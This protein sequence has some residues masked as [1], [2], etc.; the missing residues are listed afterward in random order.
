MTSRTRA[1]HTVCPYCNE[2]V[3]LEELI[4]GKC[5]LC[6]SALED[7]EDDCLE[8]D[9]GLERSDLSWLICHYF[10][11]KKLDDLGANPLQA[12]QIIEKFEE[13]RESG[14]DGESVTFE[15]ELPYTRREQLLPKR[16]ADCG[17]LF[18][19]GGKKIFTGDTEKPGY[20]VFFRC[21]VCSQ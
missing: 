14:N 16:C 1:H 12:M 9:D 21:P 19:R 4:G 5:P 3:Y 2:E 7:L 11:F 17:H 18:L 20:S 15:I 13:K 6:G 10:L 8:I